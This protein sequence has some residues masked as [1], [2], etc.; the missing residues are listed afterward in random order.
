MATLVFKFVL[1][2]SGMYLAGTH[3]VLREKCRNEKSI[4][5]NAIS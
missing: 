4:Y 1:V 2:I 5:F 3:P